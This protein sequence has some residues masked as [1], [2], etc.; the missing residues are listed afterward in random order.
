[1]GSALPFAAV[2]HEIIG[3]QEGERWLSEL[4]RRWYILKQWLYFV[5][6]NYSA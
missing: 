5:G 4:G 3:K 2:A 6:C 1:M